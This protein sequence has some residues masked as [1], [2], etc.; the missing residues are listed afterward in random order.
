MTLL[1]IFNQLEQQNKAIGQFNVSDSNQLKG[2]MKAVERFNCPVIIGLSEGEREFFGLNQIRCL[3]DSYK[4]DFNLEIFISAD[5][6]KSF[7]SVKAAFDA[8]FDYIHFDGS[9]L[10]LE[11]NIE[12]T[13]KIVDYVKSCNKDAFVEGELGYLRGVSKIQEKVELSPEDFTKPAE[14]ERFIAE[15]GVDSLAIAIGNFHGIALKSEE[16]LDISRL[17]EIKD[18]ASRIFLV[19]HGA[20]GIKDED[21]FQAIKSGIRKININTELRVAYSDTLKKTLNATAE[22]TPYKNF[23]PAIEAIKNQVEKKLKLFGW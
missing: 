11:E 2:V 18:S 1:E 7:E 4:K 3:V 21:I 22:T 16:K 9:N 23:A 15:T 19:L 14:V 6:S 13:K 10:S 12:Q 17:K 8:G 5:H 20:S